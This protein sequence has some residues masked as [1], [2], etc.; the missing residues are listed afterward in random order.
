[1]SALER[2][3]QQI[4]ALMNA[5]QSNQSMHQAAQVSYDARKKIRVRTAQAVAAR[6]KEHYDKVT[7]SVLLSSHQLYQQLTEHHEFERRLLDM[8]SEREQQRMR[9]K[10]R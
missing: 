2:I 3:E 6:Q 1:M 8:I 9:A 4:S 7:K 10:K 5:I